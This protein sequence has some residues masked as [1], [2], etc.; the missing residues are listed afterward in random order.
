MRVLKNFELKDEKLRAGAVRLIVAL[1]PK[2]FAALESLLRDCSSP[3]WYEVHF[4]IF[5]ALERDNFAPADQAR[6]KQ[7][8]REY[9]LN[10]RSGSGFAAW[11]AGDL[12]GDE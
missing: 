6:V 7:L 10:I 3:L 9:L 4:T 1:L 12:L 5:C 8:I 2:T 11:K